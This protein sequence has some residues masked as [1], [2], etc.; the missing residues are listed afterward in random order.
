MVVRDYNWPLLVRPVR[1]YSTICGVIMHSH[2]E[3]QP[4]SLTTTKRLTDRLPY[5]PNIYSKLCGLHLVG[6]NTAML[7][8]RQSAPM[9]G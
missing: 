1:K 9:K 5:I 3:S 2:L 6:Q 8:I 7:N 4:R